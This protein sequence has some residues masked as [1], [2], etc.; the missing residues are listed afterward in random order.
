MPL[1]CQSRASISRVGLTRKLSAAR[2]LTRTEARILRREKDAEANFKGPLSDGLFVPTPWYKEMMDDYR[3]LPAA[4]LP[5]GIR[6]GCEFTSVC[7]NTAVYLPW[8]LSQCVAHGVVFKRAVLSH[9]SEAAD[10]SH[11]GKKADVIVNA[12]GLLACRLGGV[13]D[14]AVQPARGQ[15]VL[16]RN[17]GSDNMMVV[18]G[19]DVEGEMTYTMRRAV[20]GGTI[21]GGTYQLG[22]WE[23]NPEPNTA[24]RIMQRAIEYHPE[25]AGGKGIEALDIIRHGVGLR[26]AR[27]GG[28]RLEKEKINGTWVVHNYGHAGWGYQG[29]YGCAE[30]AIELVDEVLASKTSKSKL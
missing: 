5:E 18:S 9:V 19:C 26:P 17:E 23:A 30:G 2:V 4:G 6:S 15:T 13:M 22:N 27:K 21:L 10:M 1:R 12:S 11:T 24:V 3:E 14:A 29:S 20:G 7:I 25:L 28:V 16:V 8:L